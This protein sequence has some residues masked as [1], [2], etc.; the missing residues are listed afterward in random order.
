MSSRKPIDPA[1]AA[2]SNLGWIL[3]VTAAFHGLAL[4]FVASRIY[5]RLAIVRSFGKD[6]AMILMSALCALLG[7]M[8]TY[9]IAAFHGLG[10]HADT[11]PKAD[12]K[13]YMKMTF[14]QAVVSTICALACLKISIGFALLRLSHS[15]RYSQ[16]I[17]GM[18]G[19]VC[20]YATVSWIEWLVNCD[21]I[22]GFWDKSIP[23]I[24]CLPVKVHKGFALMNTACNILTDVVFAT[25]PV[26]MIWRLQMAYRARVYLIS[27]LSLGYAAV[28][29]GITKVVCQ[30][31]FRGDP[32]QSFTNWIQFFG[33]LQV[34]VGIMAACAPSLKPLVGGVMGLTSLT[35]RYGKSGGGGPGSKYGTGVQASVRRESRGVGLGGAAGGTKKG[36]FRS[37]SET[38]EFEMTTDMFGALHE[39]KGIHQVRATAVSPSG[40][41]D[42]EWHIKPDGNNIG[43]M[44]TLNYS[45]TQYT[46]YLDHLGHDSHRR[47]LNSAK[48]GGLQGFCVG[49]LS[50]VAVAVSKTE[51]DIGASAAVALRLA[52]C[53]GAYV[54]LDGAYSSAPTEYRATALRWRTGNAEDKAEVAAV[55][56]TTPHSYISSVNDAASVT[57]TTQASEVDDLI[58]RA[59]KSHLRTIGKVMKFASQHKTLQFPD[60]QDLNV[61]LR[62]T[63][64]GEVIVSGSSLT[65]LALENTL[66]NVANW[67][68]TIQSA[69]QQVPE[70]HRTIAFA[71]LGNVIPASLSGNEKL[72]IL[73][74]G[75]LKESYQRVGERPPS[76]HLNCQV[77][78]TGHVADT[79]GYTDLDQYPPHSIAVVGMAGRFPGAD[80][81][82]E[83]WDLLME[84]KSTVAPAP[85]DRFKLPQTGEHANTKWWGNFLNDPEAFDHK[86]FKKSSREAL[87]WDPQMRILLE[88]V[89]EALESAGYFGATGTPETLDYGCYIGAVMNNY[90]DNVSCQPATAYATAGTQ[91]SFFSG[92]MSHYF[93]WT[94]P[95]LTIDTACSSSLVALNAA[96]RAIWSGECSRAVAGGT[97]VI[98]SPYDYR[99]LAAAGF[100]SPSGQCKPFDAGADGY[101]R[102][103]AVSAVV[104]KPLADAIRENDN[105]L[106]VVVGSAA[107]QNHNRSHISAPQ[108]DSQLDLFRKVIKLGGVSPESVTYVEAHG[109][110]TSVGDPIE[111]QSLRDAFG[112][113]QRDSLLHFGSI[114]GNIGHP[115]ATA[116]VAGLVKVLLMMRHRTI[117]PQAS[118]TTLNPKL[119]QFDKHQMAIS[120]KIIPWRAP[121]L[122]A[123]VNSYGAAGS[124]SAAMIRQKP[125]YGG[126]PAVPARLSKYPLFISA[127][128][129]DG[130]SRF[131]RKLLS[132]V[133]KAKAEVRSDLLAQL[134]FNLADRGN[135]LLPHILAT[136]VST[137]RELESSLEAAASGSG[138]T[139]PPKQPKPVILVFGGQ[140]SD[141]IGLSEDV[142]RTSKVFRTHLDSVNDLM[143]S[144]GLESLYPS[145]FQSTPVRNL[146]TL[147]SALFA[148]QYASTK[149]WINSGLKVDAVV[150]H[151][152]GQLTALCIS[153]VLSLPDALKLVSGRASLMQ[154]YWGPEPGSMLFLQAGRATVDEIL[155]TLDFDGGDHYAEIACHNGPK[156]HVVVGSSESIELLQNHVATTRH[157][158]ESAAGVE[159]SPDPSGDD[160]RTSK[161]PGTR[162]QKRF[163]AYEGP[164]FFQRAIERIAAKH[165]QCTWIEAGRGSSVIQL[166]K[167]C[168]ADPHAHTFHTSPLTSANAQ[169]LLTDITV[170][171]WK[172]GYSVQYW[173]FHRSQKLDYDYITLPPIQFE[174]T[175]HWLEFTGRGLAE[176]ADATKPAPDVEEIHELLSFFEFSDAAKS[177]AVFRIDPQSDRFQYLLGG[178]VMAGQSLAPASLYFEVVA[179]AALLLEDDTQATKYVPTVEDLMMRSPI[180]HT[181]TKKIT[182]VLKRLGVTQGTHPS[183]LFFF[184]TQD[185]EG[186][187]AQPL[188]HATGTVYLKK[189]NDTAAARE[190]GR[191]DT[192]V[193]QRRC[194]EILGHP[195]AE[196]MR[197]NHIYRAFNTVVYYGEAFRGIKEISCVGSESA[198]RVKITPGSPED[199]V[200]QR[201]CDTPMTDSFMQIAGLM[202]NYFNNPSME[203][204]FVCM[205]IEQIR[206]GGGFDPDAGD[207]LVYATMNNTGESDIVADAYVFDARSRKMVM[208]VFGLRFAKMSQS[209]LGRMLKSVNKVANAKAPVTIE[210][211]S[212]K[213][214]SPPTNYPAASDSDAY[215]QDGWE[216]PGVDSLMATE[217]LNDV[218]SVLGITIDLSSFL[219]FPNVQALVKHVDEKL[220]IMSSVDEDG[221]PDT[222][223]GVSDVGTPSDRPGT[224][225]PSDE[226]ID[227]TKAAVAAVAAV[228]SVTAAEAPTISALEAFQKTRLNFDWRAE[229]TQAVGFWDTAYPYQARLVLA[230]LVEAFAELGCSMKQLRSGEVAPQ[231]MAT[232]N[233]RRLVRQLWR[234]LEDGGLVTVSSSEHDREQFIRTEKPVDPTEAE[235]IYHSIIDLYPQHAVVNKLVRAAGSQMAACLRGD[236]NGMQVLFGERDVKRLLQ[237]FYEHWPLLRTLTLVLGDFLSEV[238]SSAA[239]TGG[240]FRILEIGGG[241]GGTT[242]HIVELLRSQGI[243]FEYV[244]TDVSS[245]LVHNIARQF[246]DVAEVSVGVLDVEKPPKPEYVGAFHCVVATNCIHAT[247]DLEASLRNIR[248]ML[249]ED[250]VLALAE[251]TRNMFW[252]DVVFGLFDGWW[253]YDDGRAHAVV[254]ER[255]WE[256]RLR[257]AGFGAVAWS[258]GETPEAKSVRIIAAFPTGDSSIAP[259]RTVKA[260][261]E[262]LKYKTVEDLEVQADVYYPLEGQ[263]VSSSKLPVALM[264]H[265]GSHI[266][267]SRKDVRPAQ[268]R[269]LLKKGFLPVSLD[270]RLCPEV[271]LMEGAMVD[272]C[273]ALDWARHQLPKIV[274]PN[275]PGLQIDGERVVVVGWS[276][277]G[278]LA[279]SL[280]WTAPARGLR[281]PEAILAF[282][283]PT[284]YEDEW[285]QHP[286]EPTGAPYTGQRYDVLEGVRD[287]P[288][289][290]YEMVGAWEE[291]VSD[292]SSH[293]DPRT[294]IVLHI[295]WKAQTL[296]VILGGLPSRKRAMASGSDLDWN[297]LPQ[298]SLETI[299][300]ASPYAHIDRGT[301]RVPTF[302]VHGTADDLIPW[303]Q[304][305]G[306]YEIMKEAGIE[307]GLALVDGAPHICDLS[308]DPRSEA[309]KAVVQGYDFICSFAS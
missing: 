173:P 67:Y 26:P 117:T 290:K 259:E 239:A 141:F 188:E 15:R 104:L 87:A 233:H 51:A 118:L 77:D 40:S 123:C 293:G 197:G 48:S 45:I 212:T 255:H 254:D 94:G 265:G 227:Q 163:G 57:I 23:G 211:K 178:H 217:M 193:G 246:K 53:I 258:D 215:E 28:L 61:P 85:L 189:K 14:I 234:V 306:T 30:N 50:A 7:G 232:D 273:D 231:I 69:I 284:N 79:D 203:D 111:V 248:A 25:L 32:D 136:T 297:A 213:E 59:R 229:M 172:G 35:S 95:A 72:S 171:L 17:W 194:E 46:R 2:E 221:E 152:F 180:G 185:T 11:I 153:G 124:N 177:E 128:S 165:P 218:R 288:I 149:A 206:I 76:G 133:R 287:R 230:Y 126:K 195:D 4:I 103:E 201:L 280:V 139:Q 269:L 240:K 228:T 125:T 274:L 33:F 42:D 183:W 113:P 260:A 205:K 138:I 137:V 200:D 132:W 276:S 186:S 36:W 304:S 220:G 235:S 222:D 148:V 135:H 100:L 119:P 175:R 266:L 279:M 308:G 157:L 223:S 18:I 120:R 66:L 99:N 21:P 286:I 162:P 296:P 245:S 73:G 181:T 307:T 83:L 68:K 121:S 142:Y 84:G 283:A 98:T 202:V 127:G 38:D 190:F 237:E 294:K 252:F 305:Q 110:G 71:G 281:P 44:R 116:G 303:Q 309:W 88:V 155:R 105:I 106:G 242:R 249:R 295:N 8:V 198:G 166:V 210:E 65:H 167:G 224:A 244:F 267:F 263:E 54:D 300:A 170:D 278:Q 270:Y 241:T 108:A 37:K 199:P 291:P 60:S 301:Y 122:L 145:I 207:W 302:F 247:R 236:K 91:R 143:V 93:G 80:T 238:F 216:A 96:C 150:G 174:K 262:T 115:E 156:S 282:Y 292:P 219:F 6:D 90:E 134:A 70:S 3:G 130:L 257:A 89:Y 154:K 43:I 86:F 214:E 10:R 41:E 192:L 179:R 208:G 78:G 299:R 34:N 16:I 164:V 20:V 169:E 55:L 140:E 109:T 168:V 22:A 82:D 102:A 58:D 272:V 275:N 47:L 160:G 268:T 12:H 147:H 24:K 271:P 56:E 75:D 129:P 182:L 253:L 176:V 27:I 52:V 151:S 13:E 81:V 101:C 114:K 19:F 92:C 243:D 29:L 1:R 256:R 158:R 159:E 250:G 196:K 74:L 144:D 31:V 49:F 298:P 64:S 63:S 184:T 289:A 261:M 131:S 107:N 187:G 112:G 264:I 62:D 225:S 39:Q 204:V 251:V 277:G 9:I 161:Q 191:F 5:I 97:N 146:V 209:L 285:W 226:M